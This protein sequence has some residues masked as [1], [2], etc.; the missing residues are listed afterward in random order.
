M[1]TLNKNKLVDI[2]LKDYFAVIEKQD[3]N[4]LSLEYYT[5]LFTEKD[6]FDRKPYLFRRQ[7]IPYDKRFDLIE[8]VFDDSKKTKAICW[9]FKLKYRDLN[10]YFGK[11]ILHYSAY[12]ESTE[13]A[14][15]SSNKTIEIIITRIPGKYIEEE[16]R[17]ELKNET[18]GEI[19]NPDFSFIQ[20][21][22][23]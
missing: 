6:Y 21:T 18:S 20:F 7:L 9:D 13:F 23:K 19:E 4:K 15:I 5:E 10:E 14:F 1:E 22:L 12:S 11:P 2:D 16:N 8:I 17:M 3:F